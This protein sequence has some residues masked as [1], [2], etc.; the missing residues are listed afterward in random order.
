MSYADFYCSVGGSR[1]GYFPNDIDVPSQN[2]IETSL[3]SYGE[4]LK[5]TPHEN[6]ISCQKTIPFGEI[7]DEGLKIANKLLKK[8]FNQDDDIKKAGMIQLQSKLIEKI[9]KLHLSINDCLSSHCTPVCECGSNCNGCEA[10]HCAGGNPCP[11]GEINRL[12]KEITDIYE[13]IEE[14]KDEIFKIIDID[15]PTYLE[16]DFKTLTIWIHNCIADSEE[17]E[18]GWILTNCERATGCIG[19][20]GEMIENTA[21]TQGGSFQIPALCKCSNIDECKKNFPTLKDKKVCSVIENCT[22]FNF[23]CCRTKLAE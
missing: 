14:R 13:E 9:D 16:G 1:S 8:M 21:S 12:K 15:I 17:I 19:P 20:D 4:Y 18:S 3:E 6:T 11:M 5:I 23:F 22:E 2:E 10:S 7:V